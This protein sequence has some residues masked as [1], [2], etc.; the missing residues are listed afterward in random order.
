MINHIFV[1]LIKN[2]QSILFESQQLHAEK[3]QDIPQN[4]LTLWNIGNNEHQH[5]MLQSHTRL[6]LRWGLSGTRRCP[7]TGRCPGTCSCPWTC[8]CPGTNLCPRTDRC[9]RLRSYSILKTLYTCTL[10]C[11][12]IL[13]LFF[14]CKL[15]SSAQNRKKNFSPKMP[16]WPRH[17]PFLCIVHYS[18]LKEMKL[19]IIVPIGHVLTCQL[20]KISWET[21]HK[22]VQFCQCF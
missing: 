5:R 13:L 6:Y 10:Y 11:N 17:L 15:L 4:M 21:Q 9:W 2:F 1:K 14:L 8:G 3:Q 7:R 16:P 20:L 19:T 12:N 22:N 18:I